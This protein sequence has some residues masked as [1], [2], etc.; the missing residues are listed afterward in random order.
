MTHQP[1]NPHHAV[2]LARIHE[3]FPKLHWTDYRFID[4][5]WDHEVI[6]L[7]E[8]IVFR[9][10]IEDD[11]K[12][13]FVAEVKTLNRLAPLVPAGIPHYMYIAPDG[14]FAGYPM[15]A[16]KPLYKEYFDS[17]DA[18]E[19]S[20]IAA[21][22]ADFLST[23]HATKGFEDELPLAYLVE[24]QAETRQLAKQHFSAVL[25][26]DDIAVVEQ[27]L[28]AVDEVLAEQTPKVFIHGDI[29]HGHLLW[30]AH[31][32]KLNIIDFSDRNLGDPAIDFSEI[33][34]YGEA[35]V[36]E[37]YDQ[38]KGPKDDTFLARSW[39][40]QCWAGVYMM[41]DH[42]VNHKISFAKSR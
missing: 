16:G 28:T 24:D 22:L 13:L 3:A 5:G 2:L 36:H 4:E 40:Y 33:H 21:Q 12:R 7:D 39:A 23:L 6:V 25:S 42:F 9:F 15:L 38:Y 14:S 29:F 34:E 32:K 30:D 37:V 19:R 27:T 17:L 31:A 20:A 26:A 41:T 11:Y 8:K 10:P 1:E 35:F 18:D